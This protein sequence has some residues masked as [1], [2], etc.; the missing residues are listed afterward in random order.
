MEFEKLISER[1]SVR[2]FEQKHLE[3]DDISKILHAG[4]VAPTGCN[5]QPQRI[6]VLNTDEST[7]KLKKCTKCHF[8]APCAMLVCYN[9]DETWTRVY[10]GAICAPV[11]AAIVTTHMMLEA[12]N[13]G[14]GTC[15]VMHFDPSAMR[16]TFNIPENFEPLALLVMGY[17]HKD[18]AP[19][20]MHSTFRPLNEVVFYES[21]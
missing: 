13:I 21:F 20:E 15:W 4:H 11:D 18:A 3:E 10:D 7:E 1:Y 12:A 9:R 5:N 6:L 2:K 19:I 16:E 8:D 17:P 14:V